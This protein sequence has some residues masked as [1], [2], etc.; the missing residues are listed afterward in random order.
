MIKENSGRFHLASKGKTGIIYI[1]SDSVKDNTFPFN[2]G[3][4][5]HVRIEKACLIIE[6]DQK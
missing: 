4:I 5:L 3:D 6:S 2:N 1:P